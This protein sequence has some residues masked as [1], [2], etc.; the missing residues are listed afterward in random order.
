MMSVPVLSIVALI[1]ILADQRWQW[2]NPAEYIPFAHSV[3]GIAA[4]AFS[5]FQVKAYKSFR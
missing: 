4:I 2:L 3:I 5:V 1:L